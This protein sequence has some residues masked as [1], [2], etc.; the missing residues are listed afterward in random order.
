M[1]KATC[2]FNCTKKF[3]QFIIQ[4]YSYP[5]TDLKICLYHCPHMKIICRRL[6]IKTISTFWDMH[7]RD[8]W[9]VCSQTFRNNRRCWKL[10]ML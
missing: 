8:M 7:T 9:Q 6:H 5:D 1:F 2:M 3:R 10:A 4:L